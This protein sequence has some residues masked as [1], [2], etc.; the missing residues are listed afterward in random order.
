M[1]LLV[2]ADQVIVYPDIVE[3]TCRCLM[4]SSEDSAPIV[5]WRVAVGR[6]SANV[7]PRFNRLAPSWTE[8]EPG[9]SARR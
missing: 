6:R 8:N 7:A 1:P 2:A 9:G 4:A 3:P 5:V